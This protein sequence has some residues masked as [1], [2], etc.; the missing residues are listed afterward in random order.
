MPTILTV[1]EVREH[2]ETDLGD[3][4]LER[5][6]DAAD[7]EIIDRLGA[8]ATHTDVLPGQGLPALPLTRKAS[9]ITS[10]VERIN[11]VDYTLG[12]NDYTLAAD[13]YTL[14]RAQGSTYPNVAWSGAVTVVYVPYGGATGELA[15]RE[16]LLVDLVRL[17]A[18]YDATGQNQIG[19]VSRTAL[20]HTHERNALFSS[21]L[22]R[23]R[24]MPLA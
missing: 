3:D 6:V 1:D 24:R 4:A 17:D 22:N 16:K 23:N 7:Q 9:A 20:N 8:L 12:S 5:L 15:A 19:D 11:D 18:V 21:M 10:A 14:R 13:G 2:V